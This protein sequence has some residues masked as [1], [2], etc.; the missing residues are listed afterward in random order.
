[1]IRAMFL[2][3]SLPSWVMMITVRRARPGDEKGMAEIVKAGLKKKV[4]VYTGIN[5][6]SRARLE[7]LKKDLRARRATARHYVAIDT[8]EGKIVGA[9]SCRFERTGRLRHRVAL[10]WGMHP[11]HLGQKIGTKLLKFVLSDSKKRG[12]K[13]AEAEMAVKNVA[14]LRLA[15]RC[16]FKIEGIKKKAL[17]T[18]D[19]KYLDTYIV[20]RLL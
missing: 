14:S 11:D 3:Y 5:S 7:K 6:Y 10:G 4:W 19:G 8:D 1:M 9:S 17:V 18:D 20:G 12:F 16:G 15:H 13:R 2:Y